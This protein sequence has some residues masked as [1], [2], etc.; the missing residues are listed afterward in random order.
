MKG[1]REEIISLF[2]PLQVGRIFLAVQVGFHFL[3]LIRIMLLLS[4]FHL[5]G[6]EGC[7]PVPVGGHV[8]D[9][10]GLLWCAV[11]RCSPLEKGS[12]V[13]KHFPEPLIP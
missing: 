12:G 2:E 4:G 13:R 8:E 5:V 9:A 11:H 1:R 6:Q 10:A 7:D 3:V